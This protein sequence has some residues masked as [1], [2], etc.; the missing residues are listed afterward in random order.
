MAMGASYMMGR[1]SSNGFQY[2]FAH[3]LFHTMGGEHD[4]DL[5]WDW[6]EN[7]TYRSDG[8][9]V[10]CASGVNSLLHAD[11]AYTPHLPTSPLAALLLAKMTVAT[12]SRL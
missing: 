1:D 4:K 6:S 2:M 8:H 3:E 9:G 7:G 11:G 5:A 12:M 10:T